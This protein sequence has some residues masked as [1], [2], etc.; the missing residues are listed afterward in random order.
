MALSR[1]G[2]LRTGA[3]ALPAA[4]PVAVSTGGTSAAAGV[5]TSGAGLAVA[6]SAAE[7]KARAAMALAKHGGF[8][9]DGLMCLLGGKPNGK[10]INSNLDKTLKTLLGNGQ[11]K[12]TEDDSNKGG[13]DF[14]AEVEIL[15]V[16]NFLPKGVPLRDILTPEMFNETRKRN[17]D[18]SMDRYYSPDFKEEDLA[19]I[20]SALDPYLADDTT[21]EDLQTVG[22]E[23][24][25][26]LT[27]RFL[28]NP[29][30]FADTFHE[31]SS[32]ASTLQGTLTDWAN[33]EAGNQAYKGLIEALSHKKER[34]QKAGEILAR[35]YYLKNE[36]IF[37]KQREE[38]EAEQVRK[39]E[40]HKAEIERRKENP[41]SRSRFDVHLTRGQKGEYM[42]EQKCAQKILR[43][44]WLQFVQ[45]IYPLHAKP[46]DIELRAGGMMVAFHKKAVVEYIEQDANKSVMGGFIVSLPNRRMD[47]DLNAPP[48][49]EI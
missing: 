32:V 21:V 46:G 5:A 18:K 24:F 42:V 8:P 4:F 37:I 20:V 6:L 16:L 29:K 31:G 28:E 45:E 43:V 30:D 22:R 44:D 36:K 13:M 27:R 39:N 48:E 10:N 17:I 7:R 40:A 12:C 2:F 25:A 35:R 23:Y 14:S 15:F 19:T 49:F 1:R 11:M 47:L 38:A 26:K 34:Y 3:A 9:V 33:P 41:A